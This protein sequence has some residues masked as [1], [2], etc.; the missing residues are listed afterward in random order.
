M[1]RVKSPQ[2]LGAGAV[3]VL[4]GLA[5]LYFGRELAFGTAARMGPGYFPILLSVLILAI[6]IIVAIRGLTTEGPPIEPVQLRPIAMIIAAIL[7]FGVLID[8]VG[9]A[10]TALLLTVFAA[11]AR[12]EVK[13]T[14]TILLGAGLAAFTVA[15]FVYLLGQPLPAWWGR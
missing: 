15:V 7:I 2:D 3:F 14:E 12:R 13:L 11:Y 8:V 4:I 6:G 5:G 1:V 10:L 9:L